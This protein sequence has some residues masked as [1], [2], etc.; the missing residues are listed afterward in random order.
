[1]HDSISGLLSLH[2]LVSLGCKG[3]RRSTLLFACCP[4]NESGG[5]ATLK[6][7]DAA[8][9]MQVTPA[10]AALMAGLAKLRTTARAPYVRTLPL[11]LLLHTTTDISHTPL[12]T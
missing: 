1:M 7:T 5:R 11:T 3:V 2:D 6:A 9:P 10:T 4:D 12:T 8:Q